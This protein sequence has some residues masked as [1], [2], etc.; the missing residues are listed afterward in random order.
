PKLSLHLHT[1]DR[2]MDLLDLFRQFRIEDENVKVIQML[3]LR[4]FNAFACSVKLALAGYAQNS[5]LIMRDILETIF[6]TDLF[7]GNPELIER[8][9]TANRKQRL[10]EFSPVAVRDALDKRDGFT[11]KKREQLYY[12]FSELAGHPNMRSADMLRPQGMDARN[13]PFLDS[14]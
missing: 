3:G 1:T 6:L 13:A 7:G 14:T 12:L 5:A 9:R 4:L 10:K 8:W 11:E 2:V